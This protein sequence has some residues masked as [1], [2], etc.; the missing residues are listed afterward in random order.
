MFGRA[1]LVAL[2]TACV[3]GC[4]DSGSSAECH[5]F[6]SNPYGYSG[7]N[8]S[9]YEAFDCT[10]TLT[11]QGKSAVTAIAARANPTADPPPVAPTM[12]DE[13]ACTGFGFSDAQV[14]CTQTSGPMYDYCARAP[15]CL[16]VDFSVEAGASMDGF[17]GATGTYDVRVECGGI[18]LASATNVSS[19]VQQ[20]GMQ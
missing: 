16:T 19:R 2:A 7:V 6:S 9:G 3:V 15:N 13:L 10:V 12:T 17:L 8:I 11:S 5:E 4:S 14:F 18:V 1:L 20:C